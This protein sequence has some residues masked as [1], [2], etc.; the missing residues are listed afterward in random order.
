MDE[1]AQPLDGKVSPA[2]LAMAKALVVQAGGFGAVTKAVEGF[3]GFAGQYEQIGKVS[4]HHD[5][6]WEVP[7]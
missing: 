5:N 2:V 1:V 6:F 7:L 4:A 3:G